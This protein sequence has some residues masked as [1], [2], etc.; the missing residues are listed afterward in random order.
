MNGIVVL[1]LLALAVSAGAAE[2]HVSPE[3]DDRNPGTPGAPM[4]TLQ[5][6]LDRAR[7]LGPAT[8]LLAPG[9]YPVEAGIVLGPEHG[10]TAGTPM[11]I[12]SEIPHMAR[13]TGA[14]RVTGFA[15]VSEEEAAALICPEARR[16][17]RVADLAAQGF[18]PLR[19]L[20]PRYQAPGVEEVFFDGRPMQSARWPNEGF[21]AFTEVLD[22]GA[23]APVHW[24][25]REVYH[26]GSFRFPN[27]RAASWDF[28]R[29][30]Y[31]HG[32][33]CY[34]WADETLRAASY[35]PETRELRLA[36]MHAYGIGHPWR[37]EEPREF[38]AIH[39]FE[40]LD[41]PGEYYLDR[42][43][44]R[45]YFWPPG[46]LDAI[47][48]WLSVCGE[49][50]LKAEGVAH[51]LIEGLVF[52]NGC[53]NGIELHECRGVRVE[54]CRILNMGLNGIV[55]IEGSEN[56]VTR[57]EVARAGEA[58]VRV[59]AGDRRTL[60]PG[61][62]SV[63]GNRL[64]DMGR[65]AWQRG[66]GV[67][68]GGCGNRVAHNLIHGS[69]TGA[70]AYSG[71]EQVIE[72]NEIHD[73]C[74]FYSDVGVLY[75]GRDWASQGNIVRWNLM[76]R[77]TNRAV[78]HGTNAIYLDDCDSGDTVEGNIVF[79]GARR[80]VLL[81]GGRDNDIRGN[82]F[83]GLPVGIQVDAR[84]PRAIC[85]DRSDSWNLL[86]KCEALDYQS[87]LWRERYP[88][89]ARIMEEDPLLPMG[90]SV[91][92][93][94]FIGCEQWRNL[95]RDVDPEWIEWKGNVFREAADF[96]FLPPDPATAVPDR[97]ML[98]RLWEGV[99]GFEPIPVERIGP[100]GLE[101]SAGPPAPAG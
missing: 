31:L 10:G 76:Y 88:R 62:C 68:L 54:N 61:R 42:Q 47:P 70:I 6:A 57:C 48:V 32:F 27:D 69:P 74:R 64:Y 99:E 93:N 1:G 55:I 56:H 34:E 81:G 28:S 100:R 73:V 23:S 4:R 37:P 7:S 86:A 90:N 101:R 95:A 58:A 92:G 22:S 26:P 19:A 14:R 75:T 71:N 24:V 65:H 97:D 78:G 80:G 63:T 77:I 72:L 50:L 44:N 15:P 9:E 30:V 2:L 13:I 45:L 52:E 59:R 53:G 16:H 35:D 11:T 43:A 87:D 96:P 29:G 94:L 82:V 3:G 8:L 67:V 85:M 17:V 33:W 41:Q 98:P 51:L 89:L 46:D 83:V 49:P 84:G 38:Y 66:R 25:T 18:A 12:R 21:S 79:G 40:E 60:T 20:P 36:A 39:V 5:A 91:R